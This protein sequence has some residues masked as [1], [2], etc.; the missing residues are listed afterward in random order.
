MESSKVT[1]LCIFF[2]GIIIIML[3]VPVAFSIPSMIDICL[4]KPTKFSKLKQG[5]IIKYSF[6]VTIGNLIKEEIIIPSKNPQ[7]LADHILEVGPCDYIR[8]MVP[9]G[10]SKLIFYESM[11]IIGDGVDLNTE[12][13][14]K[15]AT[16]MNL[17]WSMFKNEAGL[18]NL[19]DTHITYSPYN[20]G[21]EECK[22]SFQE[23]TK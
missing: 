5:V 21:Y 11:E 10:I 13:L 16:F 19:I 23:L 1:I 17:D 2:A 8:Q 3:L 18:V 6:G 22:S 14:T 9:S 15:V 12:F 4:G 7:Q 20:S